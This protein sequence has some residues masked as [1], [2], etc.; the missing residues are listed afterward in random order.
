MEDFEEIEIEEAHECEWSEQ[1]EEFEGENSGRYQPNCDC[2]HLES[3]EV[4]VG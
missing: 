3:L 1:V 4:L 2:E